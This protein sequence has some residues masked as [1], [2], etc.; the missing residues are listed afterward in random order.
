MTIKGNARGRRIRIGGAVLA[1]LAIQLPSCAYESVTVVPKAPRVETRTVPTDSSPLLVEATVG[2]GSRVTGRVSWADTCKVETSTTDV[3]E[4]RTERRAGAN[5]TWVTLGALSSICAG[6]SFAYAPFASDAKSC[7]TNNDG[8]SSCVSPRTEALVLGALCVA[9][10]VYSFYEA[11]AQRPPA[12]SSKAIVEGETR[13]D[14]TRRNVPCGEPS[15]LAGMKIMLDDGGT[16]PQA[17]VDERGRFEFDLVGFKEFGPTNKLPVVVV[18]V[19][20]GASKYVRRNGRVGEIDFRAVVVRSNQRSKDDEAWANAATAACADPRSALACVGVEDYL[21][22]FPDGA[23]A[24]EARTMLDGAKERLRDE[25]QW[26]H[27]E[28][29]TC[30]KNPTKDNCLFVEVYLEKFPKGAHAEE[31]TELMNQLKK[32]SSP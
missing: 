31:A 12:T 3:G 20:E 24:T 9:S 10:A 14:V 27:P 16:Q 21:K 2:E 8:S 28:I 5:G 25:K 7:S 23:H 6:A 17:K 15:E 18:T 1:L 26:S 29:E 11:D 19:P 22:S 13:V 4:R 30:R 32:R